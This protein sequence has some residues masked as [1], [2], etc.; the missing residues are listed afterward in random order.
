MLDLASSR[1]VVNH[2]SIILTGPTGVSFVLQFTP[3]YVSFA[4]PARHERYHV[5][6]LVAE[7][8]VDGYAIDR[9]TVPRRAAL[10]WRPEQAAH[11]AP[12]SAK[13]DTSDA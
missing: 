2:Q 5:G 8:Y 12:R 10:L 11:R 7:G 13:H 3:T 1:W 4:W 9:K 6:T